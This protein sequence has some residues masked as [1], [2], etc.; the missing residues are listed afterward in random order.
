MMNSLT[1]REQQIV[2]R[3]L[4]VNH[5]GEHGAIRIYGAQLIVARRRFPGICGKLDEMLGHEI[6][7]HSAFAGAMEPRGAKPCRLMFLWAWGGWWLGFLTAFLAQRALKCVAVECGK[8][9]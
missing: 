2:R 9:R 6:R 4:K 3:I 7:H 1:M 5:A 8:L